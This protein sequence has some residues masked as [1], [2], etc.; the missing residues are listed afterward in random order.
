MH[1]KS[2]SVDKDKSRF[3]AG[4]VKKAA[5]VDNAGSGGG[6]DRP[7]SE[8]HPDLSDRVTQ[9]THLKYRVLTTVNMNDINA[10][11]IVLTVL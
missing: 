11:N 1:E 8:K 6:S 2:D 10:I 4:N 9:H 7:V 3:T 5:A